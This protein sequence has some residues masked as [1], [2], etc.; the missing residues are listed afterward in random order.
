LK[1][2][3]PEAVLRAIRAVLLGNVALSHRVALQVAERFTSETSQR[4]EL[5]TA[6][7]ETS[8]RLEQLTTAKADFLAN[9]SHELRTPVTVAKG[10]AYVLQHRGI[11]EDEQDE[12]L[13]QLETSLEK[14]MMLV[15]EMLTI[16][17]LDRGTLTLKLSEMDLAPILRHVSDELERQYPNVGVERAIPE[18]LPASA[19]P[20]RIA[21][22]VR[23][24]LDN[25][26]R[27]TAPVQPVEMR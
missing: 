16:A 1:E 5:E 24:L 8:E 18:A 4:R 17:D 26:C 19:D 27:Y 9:V 22:V 13:G 21:E 25:A 10:I 20:V 11:P 6:L 2:D 3:G 7:V 12:F 15:D 23:Q 14:L